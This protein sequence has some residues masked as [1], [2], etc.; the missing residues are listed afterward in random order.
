MTTSNQVHVEEEGKIANDNRDIISIISLIIGAI[1]LI[2]EREISRGQGFTF[3]FLKILL[4]SASENSKNLE[5]PSILYEA[6]K[7]AL[8]STPWFSI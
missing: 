1:S 7:I 3:N 8:P 4:A 2:K 6:K 5:A